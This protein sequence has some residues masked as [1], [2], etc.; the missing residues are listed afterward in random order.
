MR[1]MMAAMMTSVA[2]LMAMGAPPVPVLLGATVSS[3][4][5]WWRSPG[6]R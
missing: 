2:I 4:L 1:M 5:I 6:A 3:C